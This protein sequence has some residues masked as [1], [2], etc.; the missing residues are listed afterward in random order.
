MFYCY[1]D[2]SRSGWAYF[3][4]PDLL[5]CSVKNESESKGNCSGGSSSPKAC[6]KDFSFFLDA[7]NR[8]LTNP[9]LGKKQC[10]IS[11]LP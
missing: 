3:G 4:D 7:D 8:L 11:V 9:T 5:C 6:V 2:V 10:Q 1:C